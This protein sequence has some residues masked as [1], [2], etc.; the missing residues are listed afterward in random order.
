M[1]NI[2]CID[3]PRDQFS[4]PEWPIP[5]LPSRGATEIAVV[6]AAHDR[7]AIG[8]MPSF[9]GG[10]SWSYCQSLE[11][12][13]GT[14]S[15]VIVVWGN[16]IHLNDAPLPNGAIV[17]CNDLM[18]ESEARMEYPDCVVMVTE[19]SIRQSVLDL[20]YTLII[21]CNYDGLICV[22]YA[23]VREAF[24]RGRALTSF[25]RK[26]T[27]AQ[28]IPTLFS[29]ATAEIRCSVAAVCAG[30]Y[31]SE[32]LLFNEAGAYKKIDDWAK[33][34]VAQFGDDVFYVIW[35]VWHNEAESYESFVLVTE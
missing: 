14:A 32:E 1:C 34:V 2:E 25:A 15:W 31:I 30:I 7:R 9:S 22:D 29:P 26:L 16:E 8:E 3:A 23:D 13:T 19:K 10:V 35:C 5:R 21:A 11:D 33:F 18:Q 28:D 27:G 4:A 24:R 6:A 20:L 12:L 17:I